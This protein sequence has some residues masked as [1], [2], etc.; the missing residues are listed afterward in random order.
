MENDTKDLLGMLKEWKEEF[1]SEA[2]YGNH[3]DYNLAKS[4]YM[5][6]KWTERD[7]EL[8]ERKTRRRDMYEDEELGMFY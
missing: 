1:D 5:L 3:V 8:S 4:K 2:Y 7:Q 6:M